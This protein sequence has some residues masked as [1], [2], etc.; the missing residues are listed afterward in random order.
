MSLASNVDALAARIAVQ[1][2]SIS[3]KLATIAT[4]ATANDTDANLKNRAN[5]T[6]TQAA[7]TITG[8]AAV[9]TSGAK[10]DVGLGNADNTSDANKPV[11]T[12]TATRIIT[13]PAPIALTDAATIAT[14]AALG[15]VFRVTITASRTLGAPTNPT[16]GQRALWAVTASGTGPWTLTLATG[17]A[18]AFKFGTDITAVPAITTGTI[19]YIGAVYSSAAGRWHVLAVGSG[20]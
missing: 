5:H 1:I 15:N 6:G 4:G 12:A 8:L 7:S 10:A 20:Y 18:G 9:A 19:T 11:S 3:T 14:N 13:G 16:D 17:A 2:K